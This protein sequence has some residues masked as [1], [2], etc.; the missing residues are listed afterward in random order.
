MEPEAPHESC[1]GQLAAFCMLHLAFPRDR[2]PDGADGAA[3]S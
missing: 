1:R 2:D 3:N